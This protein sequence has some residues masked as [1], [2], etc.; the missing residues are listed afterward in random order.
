MLG[1]HFVPLNPII[2]HLPALP[3]AVTGWPPR[4]AATAARSFG[5]K[6]PLAA[7][8]LACQSI[9]AGEPAS[10]HPPPEAGFFIGHQKPMNDLAARL[11]V[12][13]AAVSILLQLG[14]PH[15]RR[16][17]RQRSYRRLKAWGIDY[18]R[19]DDITD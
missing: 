4:R 18:T 8:H 19:R 16:P 11:Q 6:G 2:A 9:H 7:G 17:R 13:F 10:G 1:G 5:L 12:V 3:P 14:K 15:R